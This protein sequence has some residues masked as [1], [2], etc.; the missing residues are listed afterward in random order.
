MLR[1]AKTSA[2][3]RIS[4]FGVVTPR[5]GKEGEGTEDS[6]DSLIGEH[7]PFIR[8]PAKRCTTH[9]CEFL[10]HFVLFF[11]VKEVVAVGFQC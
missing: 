8:Q 1:A 4:K 9:Y 7:S 11:T 3:K 6:D 5:G 2:Q 10:K